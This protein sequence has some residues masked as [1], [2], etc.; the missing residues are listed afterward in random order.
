MYSATWVSA[1]SLSVTLNSAQSFTLDSAMPVEVSNNAQ[2]WVS[3]AA[4]TFTYISTPT[5]SGVFPNSGSVDGG[6]TV[7]ITGSAFSAMPAF[8]SLFRCMFDTTAVT[9]TWVDATHLSCAAPAQAA[10]STTLSLSYNAQ[11]YTA[12]TPAYV[13][14]ANPVHSSSLPWGGSVVGGTSVVIS[15]S[16]IVTSSLLRCYFGATGAAI[17]PSAYTAT[18]ITCAAPANLAGLV[19][20]WV[21]YNGAD[22]V[23]TGLT[24]TFIPDATV[25]SISPP[26]AEV[27]KNTAVV[28]SG[29][30]FQ[31][32]AQAQGALKI[33]INSTL[34]QHT[35]HTN[36]KHGKGEGGRRCGL[37]LCLFVGVSV[38]QCVSVPVPG[39]VVWCRCTPPRG[40]PPR[41]CQ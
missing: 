6:T 35:P 24:F 8:V 15:G 39:H 34:V 16:G 12:L 3:N 27:G 25:T 38:C 21:T 37:S 18:S 41:L 19:E 28:I 40:C 23:D 9:A 11:D 13:Y 7:T 5:I 32:T 14:Y 2:D 10:G 33:R 36:N 4:V 31:Q 29:T 22:K 1:T 17:T 26:L 20:L 30:N